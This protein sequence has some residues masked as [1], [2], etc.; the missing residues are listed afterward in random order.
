MNQP[1]LI[2]SQ[3][4]WG[5]I[6]IIASRLKEKYNKPTIIIF[7]ENGLGRASARSVLGFDIGALIIKAT[8]KILKKVVATKCWWFFLQEEKYQNLKIL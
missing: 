6:G 7:V 8:K 1:G 2:W 5:I 3:L 4:A